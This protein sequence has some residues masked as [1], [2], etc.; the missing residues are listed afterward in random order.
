M[1]K[2]RT[3]A[4]T[5]R[6][7]SSSDKKMSSSD[8]SESST[9]SGSCPVIL[10]KTG[11]N[12]QTWNAIMI[13]FL[14]END[15]VWSVIKGNLVRPEIPSTST[16]TTDQAV[17]IARFDKANKIGR[18]LLFSSID[19]SLTASMFYNETE[20]V[21]AKTIWDRIKSK[22]ASTSSQ[23]KEAALTRFL[24][25]RFA[26]NRDLEENLT[27]FYNL[28]HRTTESGTTFTEEIKVARLLDAL[29][30][31][32]E[33]MKIS[34][35]TRSESDKTL[36]KLCDLL[37]SET[38]RKDM[39]KRVKNATAMMS[40]V[41]FGRG[42][43]R[44]RGRGRGRPFR[45]GRQAYQH[46]NSSNSNSQG[47]S[48]SCYR[49]G[50]VGHVQAYCYSRGRNNFQRGQNSRGR[51]AR[52]HRGNGKPRRFNKPGPSNH[53]NKGGNFKKDDK[54]QFN[55]AEALVVFINSDATKSPVRQKHG[56][57][58][59][60][61]HQAEAEANISL[62]QPQFLV[63]SGAS[64]HVVTG[65]NW[66][67]SFNKYSDIHEVRVGSNHVLRV[68]GRGNATLSIRTGNRI[69]KLELSNALYVPKMR[70]NLISVSKMV[71]EGFKLEFSEK[72]LTIIKDSSKISVPASRGLYR[73]TAEISTDDE[74]TQI[75]LTED[76][77]STE[78]PES[79]VDDDDYELIMPD[80]SI[81]LPQESNNQEAEMSTTRRK[82]TTSALTENDGDPE[83]ADEER[84]VNEIRSAAPDEEAPGHSH[85]QIDISDANEYQRGSQLND[86]NGPVSLK[87][88]HNIFGHANKKFVKRI[89]DLEGYKYTDDYGQCESCVLAKQHR[90]TY[91]GRPEAGRP[92][93][94]GH[95]TGDLCTTGMLSLS[96]NKYFLLLTDQYSRF[97]K[98]YFMKNKN[99]TKQC[100]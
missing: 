97:R 32:W 13:P 93:E 6:S 100:I 84:Q 10:N 78:K 22:Y 49:C 80:G 62:G 2:K 39:S 27:E 79:E 8:K 72:N 82:R 11:G 19:P 25:F 45:G 87:Q 68:Q 29:P 67:T 65:K 90:A 35:S 38:F 31:E 61:K 98:V 54:A 18:L 44:G 60:S 58:H 76:P 52:C 51:G 4:K 5:S 33:Q 73:L 34:W 89:L 85:S 1:P 75:L 17:T 23:Q 42:G 92:N 57:I 74:L 16:P 43:H 63:D 66:F 21:N 41:N 70:K 9:R 95:I 47:S 55:V 37:R 91:R 12:Y 14:M 64:H 24:T 81:G 48:R 88:A 94:I 86:E 96:R 83:S 15:D 50:K 53:G 28:I 3:A 30:N 71:Q 99:A 77:S 56:N 59:A 7:M 36:D 69:E 40:Q 46:N 26:S 20:N